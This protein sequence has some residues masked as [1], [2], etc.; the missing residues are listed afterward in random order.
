M[1]LLLTLAMM[2][3]NYQG[4]LT[5]HFK[6]PLSGG[7][8]K[9]LL[10]FALLFALSCSQSFEPQGTVSADVKAS[11]LVIENQT[12]ET[13]YYAVFER[14]EV[15]IIEWAA[16]CTSE[17]AIN[18]NDTKKIALNDDSFL[19]SNQAVVYWWYLGE[20]MG[21]TFRAD[22]VRPIIVTVR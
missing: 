14:N 22:K 10:L 3:V 12:T 9:K 16:V 17:N 18:S 5:E 4:L 11:N 1:N 2:L 21:N 7:N 20:K 6:C 13:I 8:M 19:P 15:E